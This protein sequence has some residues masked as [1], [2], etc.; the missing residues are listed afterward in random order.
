M[1]SIE[2]AILVVGIPVEEYQIDV[3]LRMGLSKDV[4]PNDPKTWK[5][6]TVEVNDR[7]LDVVWSNEDG[8]WFIGFTTLSVFGLE[9]KDITGLFASYN[10]LKKHLPPEFASVEPT[11]TIVMQ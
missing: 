3:L 10:K 8:H 5:N 6:V 11:L 1:A 9:E 4:D 2:D 7:F